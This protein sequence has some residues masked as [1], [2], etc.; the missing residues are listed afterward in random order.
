M[1]LPSKV[2]SGAGGVLSYFARHKTIANL[3]MVITLVAG[4]MSMTQIRSQFFPDVVVDNVRVTVAWS[5]AGPR[6]STARLWR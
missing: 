4:L 2:K 1:A 5:G 6:M 3:L